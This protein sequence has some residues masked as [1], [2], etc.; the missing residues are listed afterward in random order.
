MMPILK[1]LACFFLLMGIFGVVSAAEGSARAD[2]GPLEC[3][4]ETVDHFFETAGTANG[5]SFGAGPGSLE[6]TGEPVDR[7]FDNPG[8]VTEPTVTT[9]SFSIETLCEKC[10][11]TCKEKYQTARSQRLCIISTCVAQNMNCESTL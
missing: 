5:N 8:G 6:C 2:L 1:T 9:G 10:K 7:L 11:A 4:S 3:T